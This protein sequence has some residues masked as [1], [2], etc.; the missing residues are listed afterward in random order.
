MGAGLVGALMSG[1]ELFAYLSRQRGGRQMGKGNRAALALLVP[2]EEHLLN[3]DDE[4]GGEVLLIQS[5][6][7][8]SAV[9]DARL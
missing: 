7:S 5:A 9:P 8:A 6:Y 3:A 1:V 4:E 2:E